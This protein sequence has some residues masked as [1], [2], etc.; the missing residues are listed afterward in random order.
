MGKSLEAPVWYNYPPEKAMDIA[1]YFRGRALHDRDFYPWQSAASELAGTL[2]TIK[3]GTR[4]EELSVVACCVEFGPDGH[5]LPPG[6]R[7][8]LE[9]NYLLLQAETITHGINKEGFG[10]VLVA[11]KYKDEPVY[12]VET[13]AEAEN[14]RMVM[15]WDLVKEPPEHLL[16][17]DNP[18]TTHGPYVTT[19]QQ[20]ELEEQFRESYTIARDASLDIVNSL[21]VPER[22]KAFGLLH[23][24]PTVV[25]EPDLLRAWVQHR[26]AA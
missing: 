19:N 8:L 25:N 9:L 12:F 20:Q 14:G 17:T 21:P 13:Y 15:L 7:A 24:A 2:S 10:Q 18:N 3:S 1:D 11:G 22:Q 26:R 6:P 16:P 5:Q 23:D 4:P